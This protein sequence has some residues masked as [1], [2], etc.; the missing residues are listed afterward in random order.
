MNEAK[1]QAGETVAA[2]LSYRNFVWAVIGQ[3]F[4]IGAQIGSW[5]Y[6]IDFT[7]E[8]SPQT[9]ERA[10]AF[11]LSAS[12][13][14]FMIG[15]FVGT[16]IMG[17]IEPRRLLLIYA[18]IN[19]V[20]VGTAITASGM[21]AIIALASTSFFMSIMFPTNYALGLEN[22]GEHA[23]IGSSVIIM[24]II[25]GAFIPPAIGFLADASSV[26][27]AYI[28]PL[29]CYAMVLLSTWIGG[30]ARRSLPLCVSGTE[31]VQ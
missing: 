21:V 29:L 1:R 22:L 12:L 13:A 30:N 17:F 11:M 31:S 10:G 15:R 16:F 3:F 2:L 14:G 9:A 24:S 26:Q 23:E 5:S 19:M 7:R 6:F 25:S 18:G 28:I 4:Y 20:L 8:L 27:W